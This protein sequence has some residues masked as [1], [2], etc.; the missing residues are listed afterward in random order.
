M[1][2]RLRGKNLCGGFPFGGFMRETSWRRENQNRVSIVFEW[3]A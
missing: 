2:E 1:P 3:L